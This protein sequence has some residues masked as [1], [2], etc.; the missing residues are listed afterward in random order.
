MEPGQKIA[1]W[2]G[3]HYNQW[4]V[5]PIRTQVHQRRTV[6]DSVHAMF[7]GGA[8]QMLATFEEYGKYWLLVGDRCRG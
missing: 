2:Y 1:M 4:L 5:G 3:T 6:N 8:G 7:D